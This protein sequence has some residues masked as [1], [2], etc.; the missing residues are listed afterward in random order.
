MGQSGEIGQTKDMRCDRPLLNVLLTNRCSLNTG[1]SSKYSCSGEAIVT[2]SVIACEIAG[3]LAVSCDFRPTRVE[4]LSLLGI[5]VGLGG[6]CS[7]SGDTNG[8]EVG[9][10][11][12]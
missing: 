7:M 5:L 10:G 2:G 11:T 6:P 9:V 1:S 3:L 4:S 8:P 12:E